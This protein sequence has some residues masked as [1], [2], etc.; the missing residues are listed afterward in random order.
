MAIILKRKGFG[1]SLLRGRKGVLQPRK[2]Y[3]GLGG[4]GLL[5]RLLSWTILNGFQVFHFP[6]KAPRVVKL[7]VKGRVRRVMVLR[8]NL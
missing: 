6:F 1:G 2:V 5:G 8:K 3:P 7:L 4:Q